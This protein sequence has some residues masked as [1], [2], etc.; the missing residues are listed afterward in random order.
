[1]FALSFFG[2]K[3]EACAYDQP[4][5]QPRGKPETMILMDGQGQSLTK[6]VALA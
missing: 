6:K 3:V 1:M 4:S 5:L 2:L